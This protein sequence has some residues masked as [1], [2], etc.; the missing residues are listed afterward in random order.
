MGHIV[1]WSEFGNNPA[2]TLFDWD[3]FVLGG[4]RSLADNNKHNSNRGDVF[5]APDGLWFD[6]AGNLWVQTDISTST[7]GKG[8]YANMPTNMMLVADTE[9]GE[10]KR[11]LTG[12]P[13]CEITGAAMTPDRKTMFIN[14][15]H[16]GESPSER[17]DP[18]NPKAISSFPDGA[19]GL[20]PRSATIAIT[21]D[22]GK[23]ILS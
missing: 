1:R 4:D 3:I 20:R 5:G 9:T 10:L 18:A 23:L 17:A 22:D 13:G 21:R 16:P 6:P 14:V 12:P 2:A 11:F 7:L 15:Q 19:N 8:D